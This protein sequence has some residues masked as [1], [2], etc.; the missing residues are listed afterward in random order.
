MNK[1]LKNML[2][3][4]DKPADEFLPYVGHISD[5]IVL[6]EDGTHIGMIRLDGK[7]LTLF[8]AI[9]RY[10]QRRRRHAA[11]RSISD[12]NISIFE[13]HVCHDR[14]PEFPLGQFRSKFSR[15]V[16]ESYVASLQQDL[17][18]REWFLT[19]AVRP[20]V[21]DNLIKRFLGSEPKR[22]EA[23]VRQL[24]ERMRRLTA[25]LREYH[26]TR[27]GVREE[28]GIVY[29][30]IGE[31]I[32]LILY[33]QWKPVPM[34]FGSLSGSIYTDRVICGARGFEIRRPGRSSR[35]GV[36]LGFREYPEIVKPN[37][38][39]AVLQ[40]GRR[41][42]MTN[43]FSFLTA[44]VAVGRMKRRQNRLFNA[45]NS[46][47]SLAEGLDKAIDEVQSGREVMGG[48]Q[49][50]L[51]VHADTLEELG[52]AADEVKSL[53]ATHLALSDEDS[54]CF[55]SYWSQ[56]P[57]RSP[58]TEARFGDVKL[59]NFCSFSPLAGFPRGEAKPHWERSTIRFITSG[60]TAVDFSPH[61]RRVASTVIMGD[62]GY[63]KTSI[64]SLFDIFLEQNL[65]PRDGI[66]V[67]L[68][69]H[70]SNEIAVLARNG[71]YV[72]IV[73]GQDSGMA[74][75]KGVSPTIM[76]KS[77]LV[78]FLKGLMM[79]DG[80]GDIP[81]DQEERLKTGIDFQ[82]SLPE[83]LRSI[84]GVRQFL[85]F[86]DGSTGNRLEKW[87]RGGALGWA[88]DGEK[89]NIRMDAGVVG[90]DNTEILAPSMIA[91]RQPAAAYQLYRIREKVG[92][93]VRSAVYVDEGASYLPDD[94]FAN[95]F[96]EFARDLRKGNGMLW[97]VVH[98]PG[99]LDKHP[100]GKTVL[101]LA[102]RFFLFPNP[103]AS[104]REY[105]EIM[106]CSP[107]E[108]NAVMS[109]METM[110]EGT[111]L[112]K[113]A[114]GSFI[115]KAPIASPAHV[116]AI[117]ADPLRVKLWHQIG[118]ELGTDDGDLIWPVYRTRYM[119]ARA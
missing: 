55:A 52:Y 44:A 54:G 67:I 22:D 99:D 58:V 95:G 84:L 66:S 77:F 112:V 47:Y 62:T 42:V 23:L 24:D 45:G 94:R 115:A 60:N 116:A 76:G 68:D 72:K 63:G 31:A 93:G 12:S 107:A 6:L 46:A 103:K 37:I 78:T 19:V 8:S 5:N 1:H 61:V 73:V 3:L 48:H 85:D 90:I 83:E 50:S 13:H 97:F 82:M 98:H 38:M 81:A 105:I 40:S 2:V 100:A 74:P 106:K 113:Q 79:D 102:A 27:L 32:S 26:P 71:Y 20:R 65:I 56:V 70:G 14:V 4:T 11:M 69:K 30:E 87:S 15:E 80:R 92:N 53:L 41:L 9:P 18:S 25:M 59:M 101:R 117:S 29:S 89:D 51:A 86:G 114:T 16:A 111:F 108:V 110:G 39:D 10:S 7:P 119:E 36:M 35:W 64:V 17:K 96:E 34:P 118:T 28:D 91:V 88:F 57:G 43:S 49:W 21:V 75:M 33:A 104:E 109:D